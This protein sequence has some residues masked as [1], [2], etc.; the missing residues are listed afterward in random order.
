MNELESKMQADLA[1]ERQFAV[2]L[3]ERV[4]KEA[5]ED[6]SSPSRNVLKRLSNIEAY[7]KGLHDEIRKAESDMGALESE[8][9]T[10]R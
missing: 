5:L 10:V 7:A 6:N 2:D 9:K 8:Q 1:E 4:K 3:I